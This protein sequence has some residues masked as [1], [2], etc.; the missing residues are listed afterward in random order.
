MQKKT[1]YYP[2]YVVENVVYP[3]RKDEHVTE[4]HM[5]DYAES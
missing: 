5:D 4:G 2:N 3:R 1:Y